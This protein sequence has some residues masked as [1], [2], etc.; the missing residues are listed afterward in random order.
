MITTGVVALLA[1]LAAGCGGDDG[2]P[3]LRDVAGG[4]GNGFGD[5]GDEPDLGDLEELTGVDI[6]EIAED[7]LSGEDPEEAM[8]DLLENA[9][10]L[11]E[12]FGDDGRGTIEING[13]TI[14]FTS[15]ICF[16]GFGDFTIE[17][18][19]AAGDGTPVWV[20]ISHSEQSR[21][22]MLEFMDEEMVELLYGD[23]D[24]IIDSSVSVEYGR[25][26]VFGSGADDQ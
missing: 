3:S 18:L 21:E 5:G 23:A 26:E 10:D 16:A 15:E 7:I 14:E 17:G 19:G 6:G 9:E 2:G 12:S 22:E 24:P 8:A 13:E 25:S 1:L 20:S 11:A 4:D